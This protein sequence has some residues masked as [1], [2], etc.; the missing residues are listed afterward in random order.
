MHNALSFQRVH[1]PKHHN[2][3]VYHPESNMAY[4]YNPKGPLF[5]RM[6][7][8]LSAQA[9]PFGNDEFRGLRMWLLPE[10]VI[11]LIERASIDVRWPSEDDEENFNGL[12]MSQQAAYAMFLGDDENRGGALTFERY[13]VYANLKRSGYTVLRAP[14]WDSPGPGLGSECYATI[15]NM[16]PRAWLVGLLK[17]YTSWWDVW[18]AT[19]DH[20]DEH[21]RTHGPLVRPKLYRSYAEI[22]RKLALIPYH[23]PTARFGPDNSELI[24]SE[25]IP[26]PTF[27]VTYHVWKPGSTTYKKSAPGPPDFRVAVVNAR[28]SSVPTLEE[29]SG[30]FDMVPYKPPPENAPLYQ[31]LKHGYKSVILAVVDQGVVSYLRLSDAAFGREKL[32]ERRGQGPGSKR[33]G[34]GGRGGRGRGRGR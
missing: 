17:Y 15:P 13:S 24:T 2:I 14:S 16:P 20:V 1:V 19:D 28:E 9:D 33:G 18:T 12:P 27:R 32:Y 11:Y 30:F 3:A 25:S 5:V 10:E 34:R 8:V 22:Y 26:D 4:T 6:G 23:D 31:K 21:E 7:Q 29:M